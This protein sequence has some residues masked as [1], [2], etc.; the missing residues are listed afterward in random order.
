MSAIEFIQAVL[1]QQTS[2]ELSQRILLTGFVA[3]AP[4]WIFL[5]CNGVPLPW[6]TPYGAFAHALLGIGAYAAIAKALAK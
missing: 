5:G 1:Y 3:A 2:Y 4:T 6:K